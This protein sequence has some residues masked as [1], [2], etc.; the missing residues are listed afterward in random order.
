MLQC[1][2][3]IDEV[4]VNIGLFLEV[5]GVDFP[6]QIVPKKQFLLFHSRV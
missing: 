6:I 1:Y 2:F 3:F 4:L 5:D